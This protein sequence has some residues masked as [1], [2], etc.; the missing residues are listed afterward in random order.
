MVRSLLILA[1]Q[2]IASIIRSSRTPV[3]WQHQLQ[4][5]HSAWEGLTSAISLHAEIALFTTASTSVNYAHQ[6]LTDNRTYTPIGTGSGKPLLPI[7]S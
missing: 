7:A 1:N 5:F 4:T 3:I 2:T 6:P